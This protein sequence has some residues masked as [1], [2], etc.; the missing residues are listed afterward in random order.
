MENDASKPAIRPDPE[1]LFRYSLLSLVLNHEHRGL[2]RAE[3]IAKL[4]EEAAA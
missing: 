1:S 3:A 2:A 4:Q